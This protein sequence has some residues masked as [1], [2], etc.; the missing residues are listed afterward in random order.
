[1]IYG[2]FNY[3]RTCLWLIIWILFII[4]LQAPAE[5]KQIF[6]YIHLHKMRVLFYLST[7]YSYCFFTCFL[8]IASQ[9]C[10]REDLWHVYLRSSFVGGEVDPDFFKP[11]DP[12]PQNFLNAEQEIVLVA[13]K[14][15]NI[16]TSSYFLHLF[17]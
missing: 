4:I 7:W 12:D 14:H 2:S 1:M 10:A 6:T 3:Y 5:K 17:F 9:L 13:I 15:N 8:F 11:L 16:I